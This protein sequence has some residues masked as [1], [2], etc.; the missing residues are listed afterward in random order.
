MRYNERVQEYNTSRRQFPGVITAKIFSFADYPLF[1]AP[2]AAQQVPK[3]S[4]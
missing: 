4:F 2:P 1:E 3:V